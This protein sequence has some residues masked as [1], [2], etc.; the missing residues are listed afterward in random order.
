MDDEFVKEM[1]QTFS[2][3]DKQTPQEPTEVPTTAPATDETNDG[4][5]IPNTEEKPESEE[6]DR[7]AEKPEEKGA[8]PQETPAEETPAREETVE[9]PAPIT[10]DD[11]R[12]IISDIRNE[13]RS[14][15]KELDSTTNEVLEAYF[16]QGLSNTLIDEAS[17]LEIKT[18]QD[19]VD[20]S[21]GTMDL[22][23][24]AKWLMN[25]QYKLD[26][27]VNEIKDNAKQIAETTV[28]FKRDAVAAV[29]KYSP[30]FEAYPQLQN[31]VYEKLMKQVKTDEEKGV[32]LSSPDVLEHYDDYLEPYRIAFEYSQKTSATE[33]V[34]T[35]EAPEPP[36]PTVDDR[37]DISGDAGGTDVDDPND[38]A[39]QVRK[40]L[41]K[42]E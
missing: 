21:N 39:A 9:A 1:E 31:K 22:D 38:F 27:T 42:G 5:E 3:A 2:D 12:S 23:E 40:E 30:L 14:S 19:V 24:A 13:E 36:K 26:K 16:P 15:G 41:K 37:L 17:G 20:L 10:K 6:G 33:A 4:V 28:K 25:E 18:P 34:K 29:E 35:P 11:L 32:I 7:G 8:E